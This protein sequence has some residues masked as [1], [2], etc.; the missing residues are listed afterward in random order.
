MKIRVWLAA[1]VAAVVACAPAYGAATLL[2][3]AEQCFSATTG[4]NGMVGAIGAITGGSGGTAGTY[5]GVA[6]TG[7]SGSGA[8]A[9]ITVAGGVVSSVT[10]LNP[11][12]QYVVGD[13]LSAASGTIGGVSGFSFPVNSVA[14]NSALAGG[15]VSFYVPG[16]LTFKQT[17][18]NAAQ[19]VLN[20]NPVQLDQNGCSVIF[21]TGTYRQIVK[22][23]LGNTVWDQLTTDTSANNNTFWAG[24]SGGTPN[25]ITVVDPGFNATDGSI[26]NF[27]ALST[28][29][30]AATLNPSS[31]GAIPILKD[32]TAGPVALT[33]GE[34]VQTNPISAIFRASDNAF[35]LLNTVIQSASGATAPLCGATGLKI[36]NSVG[37]P[38]T[39]LT[40]TAAQVVMQTPAGITINR[41]NVNL[42]TI[43]ISTGTSTPTANG[44]DGEPPGTSAWLYVWAI[45]NGAGAAGL[46]T[47]AAGNGLSPNMPS[48]YSYKCRLG[49]MQVDGSSNLYRMMQWGAVNHYV[50]T[51]ATNT[52]NY[53]AAPLLIASGVHS[54]TYSSTSPTLVS[55]QVTGD[56]FCAPTT[57]NMLLAIGT[58][59]L[60]NG[61][62]GHLLVAPSTAYGGT[63]NGPLGSNGM[64]YPI[65]LIDSNSAGSDVI[66][67][68]SLVDLPLE[69]NSIG[70][71]ADAAGAA[72]VCHGFRDAVNAN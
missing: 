28:N 61:S 49:A 56:T 51:A 9:N 4:L 21:G 47:V 14:I 37:T 41:S 36:T 24:I 48:G 16:T 57:A 5:G 22:D 66:F 52:P 72:L 38:N 59:G 50:I 23:S 15:S 70:Y 62:P 26:I 33:G 3:N 6:L 25:V 44:M 68:T 40:L 30:N 32:T 10:V 55:I 11:G 35:H 39:I 29:T 42:G 1:L 19:T 46:V 12:S 18:S 65:H 45:D 53:G 31:F 27:T 64:A 20:T 7:G 71:A 2:P 67:Q 54:S 13:V 63:N 69:T 58:N 43:N 17:W 60:K 8:T 34:I